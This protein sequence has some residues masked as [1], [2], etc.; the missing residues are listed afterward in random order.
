MEGGR[1]ASTAEAI[2]SIVVSE[3]QVADLRPVGHLTFPAVLKAVAGLK[4]RTK[5]V[6]A[7]DGDTAAG[8]ALGVSGLKQD[9]ELLSVFVPALYRRKGIGSSLLRTLEASFA[10]EGVR[11]AFYFFTL[12]PDQ[13][14]NASFMMQ[15]GW[16]RP[17]VNR[18][19]C[20]CN[21]DKAFK[22]PWLIGSTLPERYEIRSWVEVAAGSR[23]RIEAGLGDWVPE[24]LNPYNFH[25]DCHPAT[26]VALVDNLDGGRVCGWVITHLIDPD[27][28]RWT[29]SFVDAKVQGSARIVPLWLECARRQRALNGPEAFIFTVPVDK[30]RMTR[31]TVRRI[32]P[33]LTALYYAC[34]TTKAL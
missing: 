13:Q 5:A 10:K 31:F 6:A 34:T 19:I 8:L 4:A 9:F 22:T 26:S 12:D 21:M 28:L 14:G 27:T 25:A 3:I 24:D 7:F 15:A 30:P 33:S 32:R 11:D 18:L 23:T 2:G 20:H 16:S 29:C 1:A 17:H